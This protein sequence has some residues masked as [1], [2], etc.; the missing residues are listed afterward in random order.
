MFWLFVPNHSCLKFL[1]QH[2]QDPPLTEGH[3]VFTKP[4]PLHSKEWMGQRTRAGWGACLYS[5]PRAKQSKAFHQQG[6]EGG[7]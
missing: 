1:A 4:R 5:M 6:R 3:Q 7:A 2:W